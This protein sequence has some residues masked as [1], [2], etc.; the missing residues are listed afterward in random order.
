MYPLTFTALSMFASFGG[1]FNPAVQALA[2]ELFSRRA[3][4][5]GEGANGRLFGALS[6]RAGYEVGFALFS[7]S[8]WC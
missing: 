1:G 8:I 5:S 7:Y 4:G 3:G 6:G 2:L